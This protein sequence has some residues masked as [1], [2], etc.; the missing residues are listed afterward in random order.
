MNRTNTHVKPLRKMGDPRLISKDMMPRRLPSADSR[1]QGIDLSHFQSNVDW[2]K[3]KQGGI[4]FAF[5]KAT[6]GRTFRDKKFSSHRNGA[7]SVGIPAG[8]YHFF[9]PKTDVGAQ[10]DNFIATVKSVEKGELPP[11]L[12]IEAPDLWSGLSKKKAADMVIRACELLREKL[13]V[14]PIIYANRTFV[15]DVLGNDE[16]LKA[17][18][19]WL[20]SYRTDEPPVPKPFARY[21][22]W[23]YTD[24]GIVRGVPGNCDRN[25]FNGSA[26]QQNRFVKK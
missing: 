17:Y 8:A 18:P 15:N 11:V 9:R 16:R 24:T 10:I 3:I 12:D 2:A 5:F 21:T 6:E 4:A 7:K 19:L 25:L 26:A 1:P 23:Q 22:F 20:A 14:D 13:G